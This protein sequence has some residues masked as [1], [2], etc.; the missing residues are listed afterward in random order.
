MSVS[1]PAAESETIALPDDDS[2]A[3][4]GTL[5]GDVRVFD[6]AMCCDTGVCGPAVDPALLAAARDLRWLAARGATVIRHNLGQEPLAFVRYAPV[7][8]LLTERGVDA[9]P[10][11][12][13]NDVLL[14]SGRHATRSELLAALNAPTKP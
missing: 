11:T 3:E 10:A 13:V 4:P 6:P 12:W 9:L 8:A 14:T 1:A 5:A 2:T 7:Q